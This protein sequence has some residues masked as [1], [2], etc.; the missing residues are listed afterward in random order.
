MMEEKKRGPAEPQVRLT[1]S[2]APR[3]INLK[4]SW[5]GRWKWGEGATSPGMMRI[6]YVRACPGEEHPRGEEYPVVPAN[7][8]EVRRCRDDR[9]AHTPPL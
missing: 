8:C 7:R 4:I 6:V 5:L 1:R 9:D 3:S 2:T